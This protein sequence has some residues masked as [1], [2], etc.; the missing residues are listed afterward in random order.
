MERQFPRLQRG[1]PLGLPQHT[2]ATWIQRSTTLTL[3]WAVLLGSP[4]QGMM[5]KLAT[6]LTWSTVAWT[7]GVWC[8]LPGL[9]LLPQVEPRHGEDTTFWKSSWRTGGVSPSPA[10]PQVCAYSPQSP[11]QESQFRAGAQKAQDVA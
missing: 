8:S 7:L 6:L 5:T 1:A 11:T 10:T 3:S 2:W 4:R 9:F